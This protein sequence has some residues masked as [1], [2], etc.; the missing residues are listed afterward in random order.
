MLCRVRV[1]GADV[2]RLELLELLLR[3]EFVGLWRV[4]SFRWWMDG[5]EGRERE[6]WR[7]HIFYLFN[8][9]GGVGRGG[10]SEEEMRVWRDR[11]YG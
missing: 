3:T 7:Y 1:A 10:E 5:G 9:L 4:V 11:G 8:G 2:S 6:G